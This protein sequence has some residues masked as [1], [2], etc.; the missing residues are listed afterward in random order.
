[1]GPHLI[2]FQFI[3]F[4]KDFRSEIF[5]LLKGKNGQFDE[6]SLRKSISYEFF[7]TI[8][9]LKTIRF[10][11]LGLF[12]IRITFP[13]SRERQVKW[14][15]HTGLKELT[16]KHATRETNWCVFGCCWGREC[17]FIFWLFIHFTLFD[18]KSMSQNCDCAIH[19]NRVVVWLVFMFTYF[20][21]GFDCF[22]CQRMLHAVWQM[23]GNLTTCQ[24]W[25]VHVCDCALSCVSVS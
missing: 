1:M 4:V 7:P 13:N 12:P 14:V 24:F 22:A 17:D 18:V 9:W 10:A 21:G 5:K 8:Q 19:S 23:C 25:F 11:S 16:K 3:V 6:L 2:D 20:S 15:F